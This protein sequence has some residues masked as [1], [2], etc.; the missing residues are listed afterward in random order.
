MNEIVKLPMTHVNIY[1]NQK[2]IKQ[3]KSHGSHIRL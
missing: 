3:G 1:K 2:Y